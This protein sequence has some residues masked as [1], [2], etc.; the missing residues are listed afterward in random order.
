MKFFY[1]ILIALFVAF[2]FIF[3]IIFESVVILTENDP[4]LRQRTSYQEQEDKS[5]VFTSQNYLLPLEKIK[6]PVRK[7][8]KADVDIIAKSILAIDEAGGKVLYQKKAD[9][10]LA[11]ASIT[12]LATAFTVLEFASGNIGDIKLEGKSYDLSKE[13]T[14]S[15]A[16]VEA[17]GDSGSLILGEKI[18]AGDLMTMM[19]VASSND[20]AWALAEDVASS[21]NYLGGVA[22]FVGAM[23]NVA[24]TNGLSGTH[25]SNPTGIDK[26]NHYSTAQDVVK[27]AKIFLKNYP[28]VFRTTRIRK[29]NVKSMD[30]KIV[31]HLENTNALLDR[32]PEIKGGK[33][34]YTDQSGESLLLAVK[35]P[36]NN[37][38]I[39]AVVIG[40]DDRFLE[41][42][43]LVNWIWDA[44][45]WK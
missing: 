28:E 26:K 21:Q 35:N 15:N 16:A 9:E 13:V 40:A 32:M 37:A 14:I 38:E 23:N 4:H 45:E 29:I 25:F 18:A 33:T 39:I 7:S 42:E 11:I 8:G 34:G 12:K 22:D 24:K 10:K 41:M 27:I 19:L 2:G 31:H 36:V 43:K 20:A 5:I 6:E 30:G 17:E 1:A 44:Y 3:G